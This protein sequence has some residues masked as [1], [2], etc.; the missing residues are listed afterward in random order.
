MGNVVFV[1]GGRSVVVAASLFHYFDKPIAAEAVVI[2]SANPIATF[3]NA[4]NARNFGL[5][6]EAGPATWV[7]HFFVN[8]NYTFVDS[9]VTLAPE[10]LGVQT[11]AHRPL[12]GQSGNLFNLGGEVF[13]GGFSARSSSTTSSATRISMSAPMK[14]QRCRRGAGAR[15]ALDVVLSQRYP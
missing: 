3:Q 12:A 11:S 7:W 6:L 15:H 10:Q 8:A 9:K 14:S 2:A 5:E 4:D 13:F 1:G